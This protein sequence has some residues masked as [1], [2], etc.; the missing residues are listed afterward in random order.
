MTP[1]DLGEWLK[2]A[3]ATV[4]ITIVASIIVWGFAATKILDLLSRIS[5]LLS[6]I[7]PLSQF[8][9]KDAITKKI[10][11]KT[12]QISKI[13]NREIGLNIMPYSLKVKFTNTNEQI[14]SF[15]KDK[16]VVVLMK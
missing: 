16:K 14:D 3:G 8:F 13:V 7:G 12:I 11:S 4:S 2:V 1:Q 10:S 5:S 15:V 9:R 6:C